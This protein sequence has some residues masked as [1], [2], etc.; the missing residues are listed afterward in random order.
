MLNLSISP[1]TSMNPSPFVRFSF[2]TMSF[3]MTITWIAFVATSPGCVQRFLAVQDLQKARNSV[4]VFV[5]GLIL[6]KSSSVITGLAMYAMYAGCDPISLGIVAKMDQMVPYFVMDVTK[7]FPGLPGLFIAGIFSAAL[8]SLSSVL[9]STAGTLYEDFLRHRFPNK[10]EA[11][12]STIMK[13]LV[14]LLGSVNL[15]MIFLVEKMGSILALTISF[16]GVTAGPLLGVFTMG[17]LYK[18]GN[19]KGAI[20]GSIVSLTVVGTILVGAH[21]NKVRYPRLPMS[22]EECDGNF[23]LANS[24]ALQSSSNSD[25]VHWVFRISFLYYSVISCVIF[26]VVG[27]LVSHFT[28]DPKDT[29]HEDM[30]QRLFAP[31]RRNQKLYE[32]QKLEREDLNGQMKTLLSEKVTDEK[33]VERIAHSV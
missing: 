29:S 1:L 12:A 7:N 20:W 28:T 10:T 13:W 9:N 2:W 6:I 22:T 24:P 5:F 15:V 31:F 19:A 8:S 16:S 25:D 26:A 17:M 3:G 32:K 30:D 33:E 27:V 23:T 18:K 14:V 11:Q 21:I 4:F